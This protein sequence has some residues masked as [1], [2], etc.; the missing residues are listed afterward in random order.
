MSSKAHHLFLAAV[1]LFMTWTIGPGISVA[2][3]FYE[4]TDREGNIILTDQSS[5]PGM[6]CKSVMQYEDKSPAEIQQEKREREAY[7]ARR[8]RRF[9]AEERERMDRESLQISYEE[10]IKR[11]ESKYKMQGNNFTCSNIDRYGNRHCTHGDMV[12]RNEIIQGRENELRSAQENY[13][14]ALDRSDNP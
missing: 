1:C 2:G 4:C 10:N 12:R 6:K 9:D 13:R 7:E 8:T 5:A 14:R 11:I 3:S